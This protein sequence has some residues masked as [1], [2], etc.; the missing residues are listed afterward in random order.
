MN[1]RQQKQLPQSLWPM[2]AAVRKSQWRA[3]NIDIDSTV[4]FRSH[5]Q[6]RGHQLVFALMSH[7]CRQRIRRVPIDSSN[8]AC[9]IN[10][11]TNSI[12]YI[13]SSHNELL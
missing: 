11:D 2:W 9:D 5:R 8:G 4:R 1:S 10:D 6:R 13:V 12:K 7:N 3:W